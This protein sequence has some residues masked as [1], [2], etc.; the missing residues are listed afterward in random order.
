[1]T[2]LLTWRFLVDYA[3]RPLNLVL[4]AVVPLVFVTLSAGAIADFAQLLGGSAGSGQLE[5]ATAGWAAAFLAGVAAFFHV[6]TSRGADRRLA[7]A[8]SATARVVAARLLSALVLAAVAGTGALLALSVRTDVVDV[9][10]AVAATVMFA[11]IYLGIGALL[12]ALVRSEV[13]GSLVLVFVW[14]F[15]VFL[16]PGM[17]RTD[18]LLTRAFPSHFPTLVMLDASTS[19]GGPLGDLGVS[20]V[21]T[22]GGLV[23]AFAVLLRTTRAPRSPRPPGRLRASLD[24]L[25]TGLRYAWREY[26]RNTIL[27]VLLV[28]LPLFFITLSIATTPADPAPVE[29]LDGGRRTVSLLSMVDVHGALMVAITVAFLAGLAGLFVVLGSAQADRRLVLAGYRPGEVLGARLG[30]IV[31][32]AVLVS[33]VSLVVTAFSFRP[34]MWLT[35]GVATVAVAVTYAMIGVLLGPVVGRLG[36]LYLMFLLPF[37]D[38]GLAQNVMFSAAPPAW[39][40]WMPAHGAVRVLIDGAFTTTFDETGGLLLAGAWLVGLTTVAALVFDRLAAS[41]A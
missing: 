28:V 20:L 4:L 30:I 11:A 39:A 1:M 12:G 41:R 7:V 18:A 15:D 19:H 26:R 32:A 8:S 40:A 34:E 13:D 9:G 35:F 36:G 23:V 31:F 38:V 25:R 21:W 5:A 2:G 24:R 16:G 33:V 29:L 22:V 3:R 14:M 37:L 27:W 17:G 6:A 10:R